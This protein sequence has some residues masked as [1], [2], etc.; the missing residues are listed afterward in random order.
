MATTVENLKRAVA[1]LAGAVGILIAEVGNMGTMSWRTAMKL[2]K[3][4][5]EYEEAMNGEMPTEV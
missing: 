4:L 3:L 5:D 2:E 1:A